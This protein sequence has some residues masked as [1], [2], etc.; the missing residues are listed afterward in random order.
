WL[1][2]TVSNG[3]LMVCMNELRT[4]LGD[5]VQAPQYIETVPR[6]GYR[7]IG[8]SLTVAQPPSAAPRLPHA[9]RGAPLVV[10]RG[11]VG[12]Q[13]PAWMVQAQQGTRQ[14]GFLT[15]PAGIGKTTV[16]DAFM[17]QV[18]RE[19][20]LWLVRGQ[21]IDHYGAGEAYLPVLEA[22]GQLCRGPDS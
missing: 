8:P 10:G 16:I 1:D 19:P 9:A 5:A 13:L 12:A 20:N 18:A 17:A 4:A 6:R 2:T 22:L 11:G 15:G 3:A 21:C 14:V 7:W